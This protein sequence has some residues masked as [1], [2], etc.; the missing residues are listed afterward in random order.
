MDINFFCH[1]RKSLYVSQDELDGIVEKMVKEK[2]LTEQGKQEI[3]SIIQNKYQKG[4]SNLETMINSIED[5]LKTVESQITRITNDYIQG[6]IDAETYKGLEREKE[7]KKA[8]LGLKIHNRKG[9]KR[10]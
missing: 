4:C 6:K 5:N 3:L 2:F 8:H 10:S 9:N 1:R 7:L